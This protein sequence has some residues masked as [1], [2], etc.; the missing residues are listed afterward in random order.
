LRH[1]LNGSC[2]IFLVPEK[3]ALGFANA[4]KQASRLKVFPDANTASISDSS[5]TNQDELTLDGP[6]IESQDPCHR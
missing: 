2:G 3:N 5:R 1:F 6:R 4:E